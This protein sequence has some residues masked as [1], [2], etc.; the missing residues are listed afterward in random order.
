ME[1][2]HISYWIYFFCNFSSCSRQ[3]I[4]PII[5]EIM[6]KY[7]FSLKSEKRKNANNSIVIYFFRCFFGQSEQGRIF[8]KIKFFRF[9]FFSTK[10]G[11]RFFVFFFK[12]YQQKS[13]IPRWSLI[14]KKTQK[15][16]SR[17]PRVE[18]PKTALATSIFIIFFPD[19]L[20]IENSSNSHQNTGIDNIAKL[21]GA[22]V[23]VFHIKSSFL[24]LKWVKKNGWKNAHFH[25]F[26]DKNLPVLT[27]IWS[28]APLKK[29]TTLKMVVDP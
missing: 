5:R 9:Y 24:S 22:R 15:M 11:D 12:K 3:I 17:P 4:E 23:E 16:V 1:K 21:T 7:L 26:R 19:F 13:I 29:K 2:Y 10:N 28:A 18:P 14:C 6:T 20:C 8:V 27:A 25:R